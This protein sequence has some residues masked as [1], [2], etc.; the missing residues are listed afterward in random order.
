MPHSER[1]NVGVPIVIELRGHVPAKKNNWRPRK[2]GGIGITDPAISEAIKRLEM[3]IPGTVRDL[4]LESP[5]IEF[6]FTYQKANWD[7]DNAVTTILDVLVKYG[8]L[9]N[10]N[11]KRCNGT[12]TIH[13][14]IKGEYDTLKLVLIPQAQA[15]E[16]PVRYV[17]PRRRKLPYNV[18]PE[19]PTPP[20][21]EEEHVEVSWDE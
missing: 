9:K 12:I 7:R 21:M 10:D 17:R 15:L 20:D 2:G 1:S 11:L 18:P 8:T 13:P 19:R 16:P 5:D 4:N 6:S 14:A 3:Q